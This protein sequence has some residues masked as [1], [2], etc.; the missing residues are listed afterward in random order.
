M[1]IDNKISSLLQGLSHESNVR[2]NVGD[3][4]VMVRAFDAAT[5]LSLQTSVYKGGNYIPKSVRNV[6]G[7]RISPFHSSVNA[8]LSID[9]EGFQINLN[10]LGH[11]TE[12]NRSDFKDLLEDFGELADKWRSYLDEMDRNDLVYVPVKS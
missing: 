10:Y 3:S 4:D 11:M 5:K 6:V 7:K 9:E 12:M 1:L 2:I 8:Y